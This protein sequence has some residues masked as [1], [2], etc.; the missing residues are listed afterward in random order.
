V[1]GKKTDL[2]DGERIAEL[3]P[4]G[5][6]AGSYV[7]PVAI[8]VLRDLTRYRTKLVQYQSSITLYELIAGIDGGDE[9][10]FPENRDRVKVLYEPARRKLLPLASDFVRRTLFRIPIRAEAFQPGK[11]KQLIEVILHASTKGDLKGGR[12]RLRGQTYGSPISELAD[13]IRR[14]KK[15]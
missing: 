12:V 1:R 11:L 10:H 2:K 13:Q 14:G 6:L 9:A 5:R 7:P 3:L 4:D 8:R 15:S